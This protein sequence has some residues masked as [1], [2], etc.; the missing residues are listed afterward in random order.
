MTT[1]AEDLHVSV[2]V[3][4]FPQN[5]VRESLPKSGGSWVQYVTKRIQDECAN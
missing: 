2:H 3:A 4:E 5:Y 1:L